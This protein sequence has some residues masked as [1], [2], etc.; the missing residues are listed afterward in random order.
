MSARFTDTDD[1]EEVV[2]SQARL[3]HFNE[4]TP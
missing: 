3:T 2:F 4:A 1:F